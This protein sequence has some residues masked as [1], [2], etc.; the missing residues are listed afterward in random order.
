MKKICV[1][2]NHMDQGGVTSSLINFCKQLHRLGHSVD[3]L[4]MNG[5]YN[6]DIKGT[7]LLFLKGWAKYWNLGIKEFS[8][9]GILKK[10]ILLPLVLCKKIS[11][12]YG[13]WIK[14]IFNGYKLKDPYDVV[15]AYNQCAP[16]YY[17]ALNCVNARRK[18]AVIHGDVDYMGE[19]ES[20]SYILE[21]FDK[22]ACVSNAVADGFKRRFSRIGDKFTTLYN[23][24]DIES[25]RLKASEPTS[26]IFDPNKINI[27]SVARHDNAQKGVNRIPEIVD[28]LLKRSLTNFHWYIVGGGED[29]E[30]NLEYA[31]RLGV[32]KHITFCGPRNNPFPIIKLSDFLVLTSH[33]E[34]FGMV[35]VEAQ[36]LNKPSVVATY[37]SVCEVMIDGVNGIVAQQSIDSLADRIYEMILDKEGIRTKLRQ[38][39]E[40]IPYTNTIA[41]KQLEELIKVE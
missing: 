21:N 18:I 16:C 6:V 9:L 37:P 31:Q 32:S 4:N 24:L 28:L 29:Y 34:A 15:F 12:R 11:N 13:A 36:V 10:T 38:N 33:T 22:I 19:I 17:F 1:I 30:Y 26:V 3:L 39:L 5:N 2:T 25:I 14:T 40:R 8:S 20:W 7:R 27:V 23:M 35:V 41:I